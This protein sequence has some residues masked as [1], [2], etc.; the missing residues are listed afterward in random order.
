MMILGVAAALSAPVAAVTPVQEKKA[1]K[2]VALKQL[3]NVRPQQMLMSMAGGAFRVPV[4]LA[5]TEAEFSSFVV[6]DVNADGVSWKLLGSGSMTALNYSY[7]LA[8]SADDWVY[9]PL[10]GIPADALVTVSWKMKISNPGCTE[11]LDFGFGDLCNAS[12]MTTA[13]EFTLTDTSYKEYTVTFHAPAKEIFYIGFHAASAAGQSGISIRT[14]SINYQQTGRPLPFDIVPTAQEFADDCIVYDANADGST[15]EYSP[16]EG[17][18]QYYYNASNKADDWVF[19]PAIDF[20]SG[21]AFSFSLDAKV[22]SAQSPES[23]EVC[24]GPVANPEAMVS[25]ASFMSI[26]NNIWDVYE[27]T[28]SVPDGG[29]GYIGIH[30]VSDANQWSLYVR[31]IHVDSGSED[32]PEAPALT[33]AVDGTNVSIS[34]TKPSKTCGGADLA[35]PVGVII[36]VDGN[37]VKTFEPSSA[38]SH[39]FTTELAVGHHVISAVAYFD[40]D[41]GRVSGP[42]A[43]AEVDIEH[44]QGYVY[45]L[46]FSM[47]PTEGEFALLEQNC[48]DGSRWEYDNVDSSV[49]HRHPGTGAADAWLFFPAF[50]VTDPTQILEI[51]VDARAYMEMFPEN[52]ELMIGRAADPAGMTRLAALDPLTRYIYAP[53]KGTYIAPEAGSYVVGIHAF[54]P[55]GGHTLNVR[56]LSVVAS[57][58]SALAPAEAEIISALPDASGANSVTVRFRFPS[59]DIAGNSLS[60]S[61]ALTA[62]VTTPA[63]TKSATG[64]PGSEATVTLR[65]ISGDNRV[66]VAVSSPSHGAG[67]ETSVTVRCGLDKPS[68][69]AVTSAIAA[70]N[71]SMT[72]SWTDPATGATGGAVGSAPMQ[73]IVYMPDASGM[74]W[75]EIARTEPGVGSYT[76]S[77]DASEAQQSVLIGVSAVNESGEGE[78]APVADV[79][80]TP[81]PLPLADTFTSGRY[82]YEPVITLTPDADAARSW[83]M[84]Y[85][86]QIFSEVPEGVT[87]LYCANT[88]SEPAS[89]GLV[90][91]PKV[92]TVVEAPVVVKVTVYASQL[93]PK[94]K[95]LGTTASAE[96]VEIGEIPAGGENGWKEY[97]FTLPASLSGEQWMALTLRPEFA[98]KRDE[99]LAVG[100]YA[101]KAQY[102]KDV[103]VSLSLVQQM[104]VGS[105]YDIV[106]TIAN[107]G[108]ERVTVPAAHLTVASDDNERG[109]D[110]EGTPVVLAPGAAESLTFSFIPAVENLGNARFNVTLPGFTDDLPANNTAESEAIV[111]D[112]G[113][114]LVKDLTGA[115]NPDGSLTLSWSYP[116]AKDVVID[117]VEAYESFTYAREIGEWL[118]ID[119]D[120]KEVCGTGFTMPGEYAP[121]AFLVFDSDVITD[122]VDIRPNSGSKCFMVI[123]PTDTSAA[124]DWLIS[125]EVVP[126]SPVSFM[127]N[128]LSEEYGA[129]Y[130][131]VMVSSTT[132]DRSAFTLLQTYSKGQKEWTEINFTLPADARY[133]AF[134]YRT[135]D[136]FGILLDDISYSPADVAA[137]TGFNVYRN[138]SVVAEEIAD[139]RF[140][141]ES[142]ADGDA[143]N[144]AAV[145]RIGSNLRVHPL[146]NTFVYSASGVT[147]P[148]ASRYI[149]VGV[150]CIRL[151]GF[152][153]ESIV[154]ADTA[155][156]VV[157]SFTAADDVTSV[158]LAPGIY[159]VDAG[160]MKLKTVVKQ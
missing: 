27:G 18:M 157:S 149:T 138:G 87:A 66:N 34:V 37:E 47:A 125:P 118:N 62:A 122:R 32:A 36:S 99:L 72:V 16:S 7:S 63:E 81:Y 26:R 95:V 28:V 70:D 121:K 69:P 14:I 90:Q 124:D 126:G 6:D 104:T 96:Y 158:T 51:S 133:F 84:D 102:N 100:S 22:A 160:G 103:E 128:I 12:S 24:Y 143:F 21:G 101:V 139:N 9:I 61:E 113:R 159:L 39:N 49:R 156:R 93:A 131:D 19:L 89:Y 40:G 80:G 146:S 5:P 52:V 144:V 42:S 94:V 15:W 148:D 83:G 78:I 76:Y 74:Y 151:C 10:A 55:M 71:L 35:V 106:C 41:N 120:G 30:A 152:A 53:L 85:L 134:H 79:L 114:P 65:A 105:E 91:F 141:V 20:G 60:A 88:A 56:N 112:G 123:T 46:P 1:V 98:R 97:A 17:A 50:E 31:N 8:K 86:H 3:Q 68:A 82:L 127:M 38:T 13:K 64:L 77:V 109:I 11:K 67:R 25:Q 116:E 155:G 73:H 59:D 110:F 150:G 43:T 154:I 57:G 75:Q 137:P 119:G 54:T 4:T 23:F 108:L 140:T 33:A 92:S 58:T 130:I 132:R 107:R 147:A 29:T 153:G 48:P 45:P 117:D 145:T 2:S 142:P 135:E 111:T 129:E 44:A 115:G 136:V